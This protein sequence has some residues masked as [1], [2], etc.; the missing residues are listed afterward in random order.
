MRGKQKFKESECS[1]KSPGDME[2][3]SGKKDLDYVDAY[4]DAYVERMGLS[5]CADLRKEGDGTT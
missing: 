3:D 1:Q 5:R 2:R 4:V